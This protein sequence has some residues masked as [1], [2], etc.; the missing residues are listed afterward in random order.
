M[1][2]NIAIIEDSL[3]MR[4]FLKKFLGQFY[5]IIEFENAK[6]ALQRI[7]E[8]ELADLILLDNF[9]PEVNG[10]Y[11][12]EIINH[13]GTFKDKPVVIL[14]GTQ[15]SRERVQFLEGGGADFISKPFN[16]R[17]LFLRVNRLVKAG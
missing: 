4:T 13:L 16:P 5:D 1:R 8:L 3:M 12:L 10:A 11:F 2:K 9:M 6:D 7:K 14:S 15:E 17:E